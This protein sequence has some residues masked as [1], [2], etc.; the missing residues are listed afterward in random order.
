MLLLKMAHI[1]FFTCSPET[2]RINDYTFDQEAILLAGNNAEGNF[3]IKYYEGKFNAYQRTYVISND[4]TKA[5]LQYL[6]YALKLCLQHFKSISQGTATKFLTAQ[7][8]NSFEMPIP[9][10]YVQKKIASI[11]RTFDEKIELN[12]KIN[13]NLTKIAA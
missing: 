9:E 13:Q 1:R 8:L 11:L 10:L 7:I 6:Y 12:T 3:N 4:P 5:D 2:L